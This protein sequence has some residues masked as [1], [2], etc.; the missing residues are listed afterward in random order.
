MDNKR[1]T[2]S[3]NDRLIA[4]VAGGIAQ[5][6]NIDPLLVRLGFAFISLVNGL[7]IVLY[8]ILWL[9]LPNEDSLAS[10]SRSQVRESAEEIRDT[11]RSLFDR[12]LDLLR[13]NPNN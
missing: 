8:F 1:L 13:T 12:L 7:G 3:R 9:L 5:T 11:A 10:D 4:G 2:R 6:Y